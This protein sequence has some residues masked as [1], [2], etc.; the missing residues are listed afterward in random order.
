MITRLLVEAT[1]PMD[2]D[3]LFARAC[4]DQDQNQDQAPDGALIF[5][6]H[7]LV[8]E[9]LNHDDRI[10]HATNDTAPV[11]S[12]RRTVIPH[13]S[14]G[15]A[16][17]RDIVMVSGRLRVWRLRLTLWWQH[18]RRGAEQIRASAVAMLD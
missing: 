2:P 3:A 1:Y 18:R 4:P 17:W 8:I 6:G 10:L 15:T 9:H 16:Q 12:L 7:R 13:R 5:A 11:R 14:G